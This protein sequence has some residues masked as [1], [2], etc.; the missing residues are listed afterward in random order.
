MEKLPNADRP[1]A[2]SPGTGSAFGT[3]QREDGSPA[4][5]ESPEE[6]ADRN[7]VELLQ[8]LRVLQAGIQIIFAFLLTIPFT[9]RFAQLSTTQ[10]DVYVA[11][12]L[13]S[14]ASMAALAA[15]AAI[16]RGLFRRGKKERVVIISAHCARFGILLLAVAL[17]CAVFLIIDIVLGLVAAVIVT[18]CAAL[19]FFALWFLLPRLLRRH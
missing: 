8:E 5:H 9:A 2:S 3:D 7:M 11:T 6:R 16:H 12:L 4:R 18:G 13:T 17:D 15:P 19:M 1:R 14:L 10:R